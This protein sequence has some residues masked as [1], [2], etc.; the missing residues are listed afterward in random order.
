MKTSP[1]KVN[2]FK[3]FIINYIVKMIPETLT[4]RD[5]RVASIIRRTCASYLS[6][7]EGLKFKNHRTI[8]EIW[9][10]DLFDPNIEENVER[11]VGSKLVSLCTSDLQYGD[12][13]VNISIDP[14]NGLRLRCV[15]SLTQRTI[16]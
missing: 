10:F 5:N 12:V 15:L 2:R 9:D 6:S 3:K 13:D 8:K 11:K 4:M 1:I 7:T 14:D 16:D